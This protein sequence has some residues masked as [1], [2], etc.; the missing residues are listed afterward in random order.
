MSSRPGN[1]E[2]PCPQGSFIETNQTEVVESFDDFNFDHSLLRG[3]YGY[4]WEKPTPIQQRAIKPMMDGLDTLAQ[5]QSGTGKTGA[6]SVGALAAVDA[7][8]CSAQVL[9]LSPT[10]ELADQ[11]YDVISDVGQ[12]I[13]GLSI[14]RCVGGTRV[15]D[16]ISDLKRACQ[17]VVGTPGRLF[18]M[19]EIN[20]LQLDRLKM[21]ILDEADEMLDRGFRDIMYDT[22]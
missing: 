21:I 19:I 13:D 18:H 4:G 8:D 2:T 1:T 14:V 12:F 10:R 15:R 11:T 6:F 17:I 20:A 7:A 3:I 22:F 5:A 9:I 16:T